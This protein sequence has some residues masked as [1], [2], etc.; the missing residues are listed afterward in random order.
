MS[1]QMTQDPRMTQNITIARD[2]AEHIKSGATD[3]SSIWAK[4]WSNDCVSIECDGSE[5]K[6][7][8]AIRTKCEKWMNET[9]LHSCEVDGPYANAEGF[10]LKYTLDCESKVGLFPRMT[11]SEIATYTVEGGKV[12]R[13]SFMLEPM[14]GM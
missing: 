3:D 10:S 4:H 8:D 13:E 9:T 2:V 6:G 7:L 5:H 1:E 12:T 14:P 11:M